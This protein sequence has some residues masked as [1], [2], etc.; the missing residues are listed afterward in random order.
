MQ[1]EGVQQ[2]QKSSPVRGCCLGLSPP[3][4]GAA[5]K[6]YGGQFLPWWLV[7]ESWGSGDDNNTL[8]DDSW[9]GR[10]LL[11]RKSLGRQVF[12]Y[13]DSTLVSM[14]TSVELGGQRGAG[15]GLGKGQPISMM[16]AGELNVGSL[17]GQLV[18]GWFPWLLVRGGQQKW[19]CRSLG[20]RT[21]RWGK[22]VVSMVTARGG[23]T[24]FMGVTDEGRAV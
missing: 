8:Y 24:I 3:G 20:W 7:P 19:S 22:C 1:T 23:G 9:A 4:E 11:T 18:G 12:C 14:A 6:T 2:L 13:P 10:A 16:R 21:V 5:I 17:S 15:V